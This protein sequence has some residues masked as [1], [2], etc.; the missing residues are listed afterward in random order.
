MGLDSVELILIVEDTFGVSIRD[1]EA[2]SV[3]TVGELSELVWSK[4]KDRSE[5]TNAPCASQHAFYQLR[6]AGKQLFDIPRKRFTPSTKLT[7]LLLPEQR[8]AKWTSLKEACGAQVWPELLLPTSVSWLRLLLFLF[9]FYSGVV[10]YRRT[11]PF[12]W[13]RDFPAQPMWYWLAGVGFVLAVWANVYIGRRDDLRKQFPHHLQTAG[14]LSE[15]VA[16]NNPSSFPEYRL[17][18]TRERVGI[19]IREILREEFGITKA[20]EDSD[21]FVDD[22][23]ID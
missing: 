13:Q 3:R 15:Y 12:L 11:W 10:I 4:L 8:S 22:L 2:G 23:G 21:A 1:D 18:W 17:T 14:Q 7:E 20:A 9:S 19:R 6:K 16:V 5:T